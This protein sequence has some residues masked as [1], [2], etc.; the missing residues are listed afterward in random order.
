M[1]TRYTIACVF[2]MALAAA[3]AAAQDAGDEELPPPPPVIQRLVNLAQDPERLQ[4]LMADPERLATVMQALDNDAVREFMSDPRRV[5][6]VMRQ[7]DLQQIREAVQSVDRA[8]V[9]EAMLARW[10]QRLKEQLG[11]SDEEWKVLEPLVMKVARAQRDARSGVRGGAA[12]G[13][14][15]GRGGFGF[16]PPAADEGP[17]AVQQ[18]AAELREAM[19]DPDARNVDVARKLTAFRKA[20]DA[21]RQKLDEAERELKDVLTHRQEGVL[22]MAGLLN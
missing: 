5:A 7:V 3:T 19:N 6:D 22:M 8:K 1:W 2:V 10:R 21:A 16:A 18:A 4:Q 9:R 20:R 13:G 15:F 12:A 17:S 14:G 11:A